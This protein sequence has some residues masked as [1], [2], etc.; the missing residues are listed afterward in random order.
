MFLDQF[1]QGVRSESNCAFPQVN[2]ARRSL[3]TYEREFVCRRIS[4]SVQSQ[5]GSPRPVGTSLFHAFSIPFASFS[6]YQF[7]QIRPPNPS[8]KISSQPSWRLSPI[9][10]LRST[11]TRLGLITAGS[12][13]ECPPTTKKAL[14]LHNAISSK[15]MQ[16]D[17]VD[18]L[19]L[20]I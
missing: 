9:V 5:S 18:S 4:P 6:S 12:R 1:Q 15:H 3:K 13:A 11:V 10:S 16:K 17:A 8:C 7:Y 20:M 2:S 19:K 14:Y